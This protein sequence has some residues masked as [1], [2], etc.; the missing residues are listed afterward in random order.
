MKLR[1]FY[2]FAKKVSDRND[3][4][5]SVIQFEIKQDELNKLVDEFNEYAHQELCHM[6]YGWNITLDDESILPF[7]EKKGFDGTSWEV[8]DLVK[9][10]FFAN[11][12]V[13]GFVADDYGDGCYTT[14]KMNEELFEEYRKYFVYVDAHNMV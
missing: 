8:Q 13:V 2:E 3:L 5:S 10:D 4:L 1:E 7:L 6:N 9:N 12:E 14:L 11:L